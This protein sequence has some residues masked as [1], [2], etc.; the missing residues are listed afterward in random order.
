M[1]MPVN[2]AFLTIA[3][4][5]ALLKSRQLSPVEYVEALIQ[6][7]ETFDP[8]LHAYITPTFDLARRQA[9]HA[10]HEIA[11]GTYRGPLHGI[12]FALKDIY[13]T[14]GIRTS[15]HSKVCLKRIP[16]ADAT[17]T[18]KLYE[19][20]AILMGKL[21]THEFAHGGPSFDL[22][23]PP[24]R[25]P[26]DLARFTGGSS[27]GSGAAVAAGFLPAALGTDT[28]GSIRIPAALCG[29]TGLKPSYGLVS[30]KGILPNSFSCDHC[31]PLTRTVE[32]CAIVLQAIAGDASPAGP[33]HDELPDYRAALTGDIRGMRVVVV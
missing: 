14:Q 20:G 1:L 29:I 24:A 30:R 7:T 15:G 19:A 18:G 4:T 22:P 26:W 31:G 21:A 5:S 3:E 12:P 11:T 33:R 13:D 6:R 32:D 9:Q 16:D 17:T 28:G 25:N 23:W 2:L 10:E 27:S 8:Q